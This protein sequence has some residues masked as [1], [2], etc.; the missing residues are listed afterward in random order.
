VVKRLSSSDPI[1]SEAGNELIVDKS[2][3]GGSAVAL[4]KP[5][6]PNKA[7]ELA[8]LRLWAIRNPTGRLV[9][10]VVV[11]VVVVIVVI[12]V[13]IVVVIIIIAVGG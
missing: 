3:V 10:I 13:V 6:R 5:A 9:V 4:R 7:V 2:E 1:V 11:V 8:T 12:V